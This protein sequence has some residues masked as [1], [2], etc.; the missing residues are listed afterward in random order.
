VKP[1]RL[2]LIALGLAAALKLALVLS[3]SVPFNS[4]EAIVALMARHTLQGARPLFFY[5]QSYMGSLDAMLV[6][7]GFR[8]FGQQIWVIRLVQ[9]FL[10][11]GF[12]YTSWLIARRFLRDRLAADAAAL[13]LA[14]PTVMVT[15]YTTATLGG[16]GEVLLL[17]NLVLLFGYQVIY[18]PW[19]QKPWAWLALGFA[20][21]LGFWTLGMAGI[22]LLP[23]GLAGLLAFRRAHIRHYLLAAGAFLLG[24]LPWWLENFS[25][26]WAALAVLTGGSTLALAPTTP[27]SRL[28]GL[29]VF[30]LPAL[31]GIRFPWAP[32]YAP[33]PI[34]TLGT[35]AWLA[36][37][38]F[39]IEGQRR[40]LV[41]LAPGA[42]RLLA[43]MAAGFFL[44]FLGTNFGID[45]TG[46]YLLP[47]VVPLSLGIGGLTAFMVRRR[48]RLGWALVVL[49]LAL[50]A[51][52][53][54]RAALSQDR[55]TTQFD[56]ITSF[57]NRHDA[58]LIAFLE[59]QGETRGYANYWVTY[60]LA[61]LSA[62]TLIFSPRLPYKADLSYSGN[63]NRYP[64]YD[65]LAS[66]AGRTAFIT[67]LH[68]EL[69]RQLRLS[70]DSLGVS[71][72]Q[73]QIGAYHIYYD[74][75]R[76][77]RPEELSLPDLE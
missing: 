2:L 10:Y 24:S 73:K 19:G 15:T 42:G 70:L 44:V 14:I 46:R 59:S 34:V 48:G 56:P 31:F 5:G 36:V 12:I 50:N 54:G 29:L 76:P 33:W 53:T 71:Y 47:L 32:G 17:G 41:W 21:G 9:S 61:F 39:Y 23:V 43:F 74:L 30:G 28:T 69:D 22:Y 51:A 3:A 7:A 68:P 1:T 6:A 45:S 52:E 64:A 37:L 75:S 25:N 26:D 35:V 49:I 8:I 63:D 16:Y 4:D 27:F 60:R 77:V 65:R 55:L 38:L 72:A 13:S 58:E 66:Q 40:K 18:G 20:G 11:L 67:T 62:E 57:D